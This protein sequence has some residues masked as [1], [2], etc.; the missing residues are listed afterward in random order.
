MTSVVMIGRSMKILEKCMTTFDPDDVW[1]CCGCDLRA[2]IE[3][4]L[5]VGDDGFSGHD[6]A[7]DDDLAARRSGQS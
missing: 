7:L 4:R 5:P 1:R 3:P 2:G 6:T